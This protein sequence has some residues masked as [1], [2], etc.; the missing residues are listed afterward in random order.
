MG[1]NRSANDLQHPHTQACVRV[2]PLMSIPKILEQLGCDPVTIFRDA[3]FELDQLDDPDNEI[4]FIAASVLLE[5]CVEA[6]QC[7]HFGL[8]VG[9]NADP[10]SLGIAGFILRA[11]E[12][13]DIA[14]RGLLHHLDLHDQGGTGT[15]ARQ[16]KEAMLGYEI[17]LADVHAREQILDLSLAMICNIMHGLCGRDWKPTRVLINRRPPA[18]ERP[19][20]KFFHA[21]IEFNARQSTVIFPGRWLKQPL[22]SADPILFEY[23]E[24]KAAELHS[25]KNLDIIGMLRK[26]ICAALPSNQCTAG[27][28]ASYLGIHE[29]TLHRR[30]ARQDTNFRQE[31]ENIRYEKA[32][33]MLLRG[34]MTQAEIAWTLGYADGTAFNRSFRKW[35]GMTPARWRAK[36]T[37]T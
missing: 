1:G 5:L 20:Q 29:R 11:A 14:L 23:L 19:Y 12:N 21:P 9:Q 35:S 10:S 7:E 2:G 3:G 24:K 6:S 31:L 17:H 25:E 15:F 16:G 13:V 30:L 28:A 32:C 18:D 33:N 34:S 36:H 4:P 27:A 37:L 22:K 26:F 8:L